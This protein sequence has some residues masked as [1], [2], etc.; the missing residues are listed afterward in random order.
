MT[1]AARGLVRR[2]EAVP[3]ALREKLAAFN[4]LCARQSRVEH[5]NF[6]GRSVTCSDLERIVGR[7]TDVHFTVS[8]RQPKRIAI[9]KQPNDEVMH[10]DRAGKA[11]RLA[12]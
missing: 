4:L 12:G 10:L 9:D 5:P 1:G 6:R 11:D 7:V 2:S 8:H 3:L